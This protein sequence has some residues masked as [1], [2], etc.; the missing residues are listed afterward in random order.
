MDAA[1]V[2]LC[3]HCYFVYLLVY[4]QAYMWEKEADQWVRTPND[5]ALHGQDSCFM[6]MGFHK[7]HGPAF[8]PLLLQQQN[9]VCSFPS[10]LL[11]SFFLSL[12]LSSLIHFSLTLFTFLCFCCCAVNVISIYFVYIFKNAACPYVNVII[13]QS[14]SDAP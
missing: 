13:K 12:F 8:P 7:L 9:S 5:S 6:S 2:R 11:L 14:L 4:T 10:S 3:V 1:R